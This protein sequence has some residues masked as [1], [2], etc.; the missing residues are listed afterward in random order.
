MVSSAQGK[1]LVVS[2]LLLYLAVRQKNDIVRVLNGGKAVRH[3][4][5]SAY[6]HHSRK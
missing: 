6:L 5:H 3:N 2:S 1:K 4:E